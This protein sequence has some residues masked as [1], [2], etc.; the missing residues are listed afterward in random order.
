M[1]GD[2]NTESSD[3]KIP[4]GS[5]YQNSPPNEQFPLSASELGYLDMQ[6]SRPP[7]SRKKIIIGAIL[8][9]GVLAVFIGLL[10]FMN[11]I[12]FSKFKSVSYNSKGFHYKLDFYGRYKS[13]HL[14]SGG[15]QLISRVSVQNKIPISISITSNTNATGYS[16]IKNCANFKKLFSVYNE[17]LKQD[18]AVCD[19]AGSNPQYAGGVYLA[20]FVYDGAYHVITIA[21]DYSQVDISDHNAAKAT[22]LRFG[23]DVYHEDIKKIIASIEIK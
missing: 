8:V 6:A 19:A 18:I 17:H 3:T 15:E 23:L 9:F 16:M 14:T 7:I 12:S 1:Q 13:S 2:N 22:L 21:Q 20:G 10:L 11:I 5:I 4:Q